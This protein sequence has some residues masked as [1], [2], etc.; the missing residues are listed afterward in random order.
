MNTNTN[1]NNHVG[2]MGGK[3]MLYLVAGVCVFGVIA[4]WLGVLPHLSQD[5]ALKADAQQAAHQPPRVEV[6]TGHWERGSDL[7]LPGN[8]QAV[9]DT[10][11]YARASGYV[12]KR[13]V[14]IGSRVHAGDLLAEIDAPEVRLNLRQAQADTDKA[15]STVIQSQSDVEKLRASVAQAQADTARAVAV[16]AQNRAMVV[17]A[18]ARVAQAKASKSEAVAQLIASQHARDSQKSALVQS[19]AQL[20]LAATTAKRY[21]ILRQQGFV[22]LQDDDQAQVNFKVAQA[23]VASAKSAVSS[24]EANVQ[25]AQ[26]AVNAAQAAVDAAQADVDSS[27]ENVKASVASEQSSRSNLKASEAALRSGQSFVLVNQ[28]GVRSQ[29]A[30]EKRYAT[31]SSFQQIRAPYDGVITARNVDVGTLVTAGSSTTN[32]GPTATVTTLGLFGLARTDELRIQVSVPQSYFQSI[33]TG[34]KASVTVQELPGRTFLGEVTMM[35]GALDSSSRTRMVE[36]HIKNPLG[37]L[38]PGM[39]AQISF[40]TG[41][42]ERALR[43]PAIALAIDANGTRVAIVR[44]DSTIHFQAV[45]L[46]R[47]FGNEAEV[48]SGLVGTEKLVSNPSD[49]L[50]EGMQVEVMRAADTGPEANSGSGSGAP[51]AARPTPPGK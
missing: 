43:V 34:T 25:S 20:D 4:V 7:V 44:P 9:D 29:D 36:I 51:S 32:P 46:G 48:L 14:D 3:P 26:E 19:E 12:V 31:L 30:S 40:A 37:V 2:P 8:I 22:A 28:H 49:D 39:F 33:A 27:Q 18:Q 42:R 41:A 23:A 15:R 1:E 10:P 5:R 50:H 11:I 38:L 35:S 47:D 16:T 21:S 6:V 45:Q 13:Y 17:N 24:A